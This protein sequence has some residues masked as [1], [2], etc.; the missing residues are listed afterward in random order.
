[1]VLEIDDHVL[2]HRNAPADRD[3]PFRCPH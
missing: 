1:L 2:D 3:D